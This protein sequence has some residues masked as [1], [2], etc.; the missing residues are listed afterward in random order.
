MRLFAGI[1]MPPPVK[2][3]MAALIEKLRPRAPDAKWVPRDNLHVTLSFLGEV[4]EDRLGEIG[5]ALTEAAKAVAGPIPTAVQGSGAFPSPRRARVLWVGLEDGVGRLVKLA[6][7]V[8]TSL[9]PLGFPHEKRDW[10]AHLTLARFRTPASVAQLLDEPVPTL[11]FE[12]PEVTLFRSRLARPAPTYE[13][14][15][16]FALGRHR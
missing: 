3:A 9:E 15:H 12:V 13:A 1:D 14:L 16:R 7:E 10:T 6:D 4:P 2:D 5:G 11:P 8:A